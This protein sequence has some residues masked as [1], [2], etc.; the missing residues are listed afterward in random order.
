MF[1]ATAGVRSPMRKALLGALWS[2]QNSDRLDPTSLWTFSI[3]RPLS[4]SNFAGANQLHDFNRQ[5][6]QLQDSLAT[7]TLPTRRQ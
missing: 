5:A 6:A 7:L 1:E 3:K 2:L 4:F